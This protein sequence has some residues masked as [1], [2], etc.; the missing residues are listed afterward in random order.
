MAGFWTTEYCP[1]I[2]F[3]IMQTDVQEGKAHEEHET[4]RRVVRD[5]DSHQEI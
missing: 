5:G 2:M 4:T 3:S 1:K